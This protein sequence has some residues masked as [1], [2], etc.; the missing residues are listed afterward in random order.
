[1]NIFF[2]PHH[3]LNE[4]SIYHADYGNLIYA[5]KSNLDSKSYNEIF[6]FVEDIIFIDRIK[7]VYYLSESKILAE[8]VQCKNCKCNIIK[9]ED[10]Q[11]INK[12]KVIYSCENNEY[13]LFGIEFPQI[14]FY[15]NSHTCITCTKI[16]FKD[17]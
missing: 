1:M 8:S 14:V 6:N 3:S 11:Y 5:N 9:L 4:Y 2:I 10:E 7:I 17:H 12:I 13:V 16:N 15:S